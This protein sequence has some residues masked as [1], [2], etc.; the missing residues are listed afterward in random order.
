M[1]G[2]PFTVS[3]TIFE[4]GNIGSLSQKLLIQPHAK[5]NISLGTS[6]F[7]DFY[8]KDIKI[9]NLQIILVDISW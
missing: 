2:I 5:I 6:S 1:K 9:S 7:S 8:Q 4:S 3:V